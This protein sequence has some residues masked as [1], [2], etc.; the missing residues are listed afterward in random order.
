MERRER[1]KK[2]NACALINMSDKS[3]LCI[4]VR[5]LRFISASEMLSNEAE[6]SQMKVKIP[7][8]AVRV[9]KFVVRF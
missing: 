1:A 2:A 6:K 7:R 9:E 4:K 3:N 5:V 8:I